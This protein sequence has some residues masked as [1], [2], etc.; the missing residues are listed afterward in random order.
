MKNCAIHPIP[1]FESSLDKS[2]MTYRMNFG[3][4]VRTVGYVWL[5]DGLSQKVLVD[6]GASVRYALSR[7]MDAKEIQS[8]EKGLTN[9]GI[10]FDDIE[11]IIFTHLHHDHVAEARRFTKARLFVQKAELEF[12]RNPHPSVAAAYPEEFLEGLDFETIDGDA[13]ISEE[14]SVLL[15]PGHS[16]GGQSVVVRGGER[17]AVI[18]GLCTIREI[19]EPPPE[20]A[21]L[22][23]VIT[24]GMHTNALEAYDSILRIKGAAEIVIPNHEPDLQSCTRI[25]L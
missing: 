14:I 18:S 3:Q 22:M 10:T 13:Q 7:G 12:A 11:T 8:L 9:L 5:I 1:I 25:V 6:A 4:Q 2:L 21:K 20:I 24:P 23:P 15:T 17:K 19:F 16:P